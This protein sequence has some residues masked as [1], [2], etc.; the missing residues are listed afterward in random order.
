[1]YG[2]DQNV[3]LLDL[4]IIDWITDAKNA[5]EYKWFNRKVSKHISIL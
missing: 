5:M 2:E 3:I 4:K 1:M